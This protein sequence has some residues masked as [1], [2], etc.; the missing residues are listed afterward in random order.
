MNDENAIEFD[1]QSTPGLW[2]ATRPDYDG[3]IDS[4]K[5]GLI[6]YGRTKEQAAA[7]LLDLEGVEQ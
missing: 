1:W 6:G 4:K 7:D 3:A 2:M 5:R